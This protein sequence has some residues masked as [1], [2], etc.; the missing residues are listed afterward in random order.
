MI[1]YDF[2]I[3]CYSVIIKINQKKLNCI[4]ILYFMK[5]DFSIDYTNV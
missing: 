5:N 2:L 3:H 4:V 1:C